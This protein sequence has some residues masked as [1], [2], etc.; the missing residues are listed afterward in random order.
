[1]VVQFRF[2]EQ[3][4]DPLRQ[5][6]REATHTAPGR[7]TRTHRRLVQVTDQEREV[8]ERSVGGGKVRKW[9]IGHGAFDVA[10]DFAASSS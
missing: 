4:H 8:D 7:L 6:P 2:F 3:W 1:M 5:A 9:L 10:D